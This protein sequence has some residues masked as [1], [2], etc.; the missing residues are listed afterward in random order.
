M[1]RSIIAPIA[2][3]AI[4][5]PTAAA[6]DSFLVETLL[7]SSLLPNDNFGS[8]T[9]IFGTQAVVGASSHIQPGGGAGS[10]WVFER[11][12][13]GIWGPG[14]E[15]ISS[16]QVFPGQ[17]GAAVA[18]TT[19]RIAVASPQDPTGGFI[20]GAVYLFEKQLGSW[21]EVQKIMPGDLAAGWEFGTSVAI[22]GN[23]LVIGAPG[24]KSTPPAPASPQTT[25]A[26]YVFERQ[27][28]GT[29]TETVKLFADDFPT[30]DKFGFDVDLSGDRI[31]SGC[32]KDDDNG[33][34]S[35]SAYVFERDL[36]GSWSQ[37]AKL[38]PADG[39]SNDFFGYA[40]SISGDFAL[41]GAWND[42]DSGSNSGSA[43]TFKRQA[44]GAWLETQKL[45][46]SDV[47]SISSS[48]FGLSLD[49]DGDRALIGAFLDL[50]PG[51]KIEAGS[52][53]LY[54]LDVN[55]I[56]NPVE[57]FSLSQPKS[58][59]HFGLGASLSGPW[60]LVGSK[61]RDN[62]PI[63]DTGTA[64]IL[65]RHSEGAPGQPT[66]SGTGTAGCNGSQVLGLNLPPLIGTQALGVTSTNAPASSLGFLLVG[67]TADPIGS[68]P[69][70]LGILLHVDILASPN[71]LLRPFPSDAAGNGFAPTPLPF[72]IGLV[73]LS[74]N[75]QGIWPWSTC[76]LP[77]LGL[78]STN[79]LS[80]TI[81]AP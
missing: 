3:L 66:L 74:F 37:T 25:G 32:Y 48:R 30:Q 69:F 28:S 26:L 27:P 63:K 65:Y 11:S 44:G 55:D 43:Y 45:L 10:A 81:S 71:F 60:L 73:G 1:F 57:T 77:P 36:V 46:G 72:N 4:G 13:L 9:A 16:D 79:L 29:W 2:L 31:L 58:T 18:I 53:S 70:N 17:Y 39:D 49:L 62:G 68:D 21:T 42:N 40:A 20:A 52:A 35:G 33:N 8:A 41:V 51:F 23:R 75:A 5:I 54:S 67:G 19:D 6:S 61:G 14:I 56:W 64:T 78:S 7:P 38:K 47:T 22:E 34:S 80:V 50:G 24:A 59:D 76:S 12:T 15:L